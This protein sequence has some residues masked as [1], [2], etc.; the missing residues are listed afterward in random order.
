MIAFAESQDTV[1]LQAAVGLKF[2]VAVSFQYFRCMAIGQARIFPRL[3][4]Q[5]RLWQRKTELFLI[6][7]L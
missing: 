1:Y 4:V 3:N 6:R 2:K 5:S 7:S